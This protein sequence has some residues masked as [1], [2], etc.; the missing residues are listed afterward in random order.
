LIE[1]L[2]IRDF[3]LVD[4]LELDFPPGLMVLTGETGAGK[5]ILLQALGLLLGDRSSRDLVRTGAEAAR[6]EGVFTLK[7]EAKKLVEGILENA[8]V[9][10]EEQL[11]IA[12]TVT[13][14]GKG[15]AHVNGATVPVS[16]LAEVGVTLVE[17][18]SQHQHQALLDDKNHIKILDRALDA[19]GT[20]ALARYLEAFKTYES[21]AERVGRLERMEADAVERREFISFQAGELR[22]ANLEPEEDEAL[23]AE[24]SLLAHA[25]K[26]TESYNTA[27][28]ELSLGQSASIDALARAKRAVEKASANDPGAGEI[29]RLLE[30]ALVP[31]KEAALAVSSR[32]REIRS[33]PARQE[34]I[35]ERLSLIRRLERKHG[36][37]IPLLIEKLKKFDEELWE[38]DNRTTALL[39]AQ[40]ARD[41]ARGE[42]LKTAKELSESRRRA[43][44]L[45]SKA[46]GEELSTLGLGASSFLVELGEIEPGPEGAEEVFFLLAPN[47]G[48]EPRRLSRIASGGELSRI[49]LAVKN[50]LRGGAVETL[51]F[52]EVD[53]GIGGRVA[54]RVGERLRLL[55][56]SCQVICITHL[57]QI[58]CMTS[59]HFLVEKR[60]EEGRTFTRVRKLDENARVDELARMLG[61]EGQDNAAYQHALELSK[62]ASN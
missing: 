35:E 12:R 21:A 6:V 27:E 48:E 23:E 11:I 7:G 44:A 36:K 46:V 56:G 51:V 54:E 15:R 13:A 3:A 17:V 14:D 31:L 42:L 20:A 1:S 22:S 39:D 50:A 19:E 53:A 8:G 5:S 43:A 52:D 62:R 61:A 34:E 37:G 49:L 16:V 28:E 29:L 59:A 38:L 41:L 25:E 60:S 24:R 18:S 55:S 33:D 26:L 40:R 47:P 32:L 45:L 10:G 30:E 4:R 58:A 2:K 9:Q 57:P